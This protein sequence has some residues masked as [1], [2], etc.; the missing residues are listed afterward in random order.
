MRQKL[1]QAIQQ[2][3]LLDGVSEVTVALSG[4]ADSM[5]LLHSL[6]KL[7]NEYNI[8]VSAAHFNH[9]I[10]GAEADGD[11]MFVRAVCERLGVKLF[12][13]SADVTGY[14]QQNGL[15]TELAARQLRYDFLAR[16]SSGVVATAHTATDS[17]ETVI[18]NL[19]RGTAITGLCG[20]PPKRDG[21]IRPLI[22]CTRGDIEQY[23]SENQI[24]F[25]TDSTNLTDDYTRNYIRHNILPPM[26]TL[27]S[28][29]EA[30][31]SR[32]TQSLSEDNSCLEE[33]A[34]KYYRDNIIEN[35]IMLEGFNLLHR[36]VATR[37]IKRCLDKIS[38]DCAD[39]YHINQIYGICIN[40]GRT[41]I[42]GG[43][44]AIT[45]GGR[46]MFVPSD[47]KP[48]PI[49]NYSVEIETLSGD[50]ISGEQKIHNLLLNNSL[51]CDKIVGNLVIRTRQSGDS[52]RLYRRSGTKSLKKLYNENRVPL[53]QR[54]VLPVIADDIGVV[55]VCGI[56]VAERCVVSKKTRKIFSITVKKENTNKG[57]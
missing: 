54:D 11:E 28:A 3:S 36:A 40:G 22:F 56:G 48:Q 44:S 29:L 52:I 23:C 1:L 49:Y 31:V 38:I 12:C 37:V 34:E 51:D 53:S 25:V 30:S 2:F 19:A 45:D 24:D 20:I 16:V 33:M 26:K 43:M 14:A 18:F 15:S 39:N 47:G 13:E 21:I 8:D 9:K 10:R 17:L 7:K 42:S 4:G 27:N 5:A 32:M 57:E 6:L 41:S 35:G 50:L 55:W 46:L